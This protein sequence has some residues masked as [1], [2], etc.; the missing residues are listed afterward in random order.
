MALSGPAIGFQ[1]FASGVGVGNETFYGIVNTVDNSWEMGRG[2]VGGT[3]LSRDTVIASSNSNLLVNFTAG[4][5]VVYTT[6]PSE[7]FTSALNAA[8]HELIDHTAAPFGL[9]ET[10]DLPAQHG[11]IDHTA[12]PFNLLS[13]SNLPAEHEL[14]DHTLPPFGLLTEGVHNGID[15]RAAP[16]FLLD[17]GLHQ[18]IDHSV[19]LNNNPSQVSVSEKTA[20]TVT[21]L[22]SFSPKDVADMASIHGGGGGGPTV[23]GKVA[24]IAYTERDAYQRFQITGGSETP[25]TDSPPTS[26]QG[27]EILAL[28]ITPTNASSYLI[29]ESIAHVTCEGGT[30][31]CAAW[32]LKDGE[33]TAR[34]AAWNASGAPQ[35]QD[36]MKLSYGLTA[37]STSTQTWRLR[38]GCD[39]IGSFVNVN[40]RLGTRLGGGSMKTTIKITEVLP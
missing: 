15:H 5:K 7:F 28:N 2:T 23:V 40:G 24:Q 12:G 18:S 37:G 39:I 10:A 13:A 19:V 34:S 35:Y 4:Q 17:A 20:G 33:S 14:I 3:S 32:L 21:S 11:L 30:F 38:V 1:S 16:F 31:T 9:L 26:S 22:R 29:V 25:L 8:S 36:H 27:Q 6:V